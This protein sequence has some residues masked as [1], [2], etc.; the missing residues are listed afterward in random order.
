M[1]LYLRLI[2][3]DHTSVECASYCL[4]CDHIGRSFD[5]DI[6]ITTRVDTSAPFHTHMPKSVH[7]RIHTCTYTYIDRIYGNVNGDEPINP[8][9]LNTQHLFVGWYVRLVECWGSEVWSVSDRS[10]LPTTFPPLHRKENKTCKNFD[11]KAQSVCM[12]DVSS[13]VFGGMGEG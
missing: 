12:I 3:I 9:Q 2:H 4:T 5:H 13:I 6:D 10:Q 11:L 1:Q 8:C 7:I